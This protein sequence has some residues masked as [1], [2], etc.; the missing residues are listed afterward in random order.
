MKIEA[1]TLPA[2]FPINQLE[3]NLENME[4]YLRKILKEYE[5]C[6]SILDSGKPI[7]WDKLENLNKFTKSGKPPFSKQYRRAIELIRKSLIAIYKGEW[8][9][10]KEAWIAIEPDNTN[11]IEELKKD[12]SSD[13]KKPVDC[14]LWEK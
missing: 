6:S 2:F 11:F 3:D 13:P 4:D 8:N 12:K 10:K 1:R 9:G 5:E 14:K 7:N